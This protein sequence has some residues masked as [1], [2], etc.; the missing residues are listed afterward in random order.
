MDF[1]IPAIEISYQS[2]VNFADFDHILVPTKDVDD[3]VALIWTIDST[4]A[5]DCLDFFFPSEKEILEAI[6]CVKRPW[7]DFHHPSYF[8]PNL[9]KVESS[10]SS[11][12]SQGSVH[13][14]LNRFDPTHIFAKGNMANILETIFNISKN[15]NV[16]ENIFIGAECSPEATKI[17]TS[18]FKELRDV[19]DSSYEEVSGIDT[20]ILQH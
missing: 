6:T 13:K 15:P 19:F 11:S 9:C 18:L 10:M 8:L 12:L 4:L 2:I 14:I 3:D 17:Y 16:I 5:M 20:S 7:D 1:P